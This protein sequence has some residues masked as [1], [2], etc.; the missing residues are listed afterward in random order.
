MRLFI[1]GY[2]NVVS[3]RHSLSPP[4]IHHIILHQVLQAQH[5]SASASGLSE[6]QSDSKATN[7]SSASTASSNSSNSAWKNGA[8]RSASELCSSTDSLVWTNR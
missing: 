4:H 6:E 1:Y 5:N 8:A 2:E 3:F 7:S